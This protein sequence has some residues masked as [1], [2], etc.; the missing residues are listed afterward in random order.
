MTDKPKIVSI[1]AR[2]A[3]IPHLP[4]EDVLIAL[5]ELQPL[6]QSGHI[7]SLAIAYTTPDGEMTTYTHEG[8]GAA[9]LGAVQMLSTELALQLLQEE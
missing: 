7:R 8:D 3:L 2:G 5:A 6:A 1:N 4:N 9:L